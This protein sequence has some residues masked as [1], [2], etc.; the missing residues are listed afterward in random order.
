MKRIVVIACLAALAGCGTNTCP[1]VQQYAQPDPTGTLP[2][3]YQPGQPSQD[4]GTSYVGPVAAGGVGYIAGRHFR[5]VQAQRVQVPA[6][7]TFTFTP[8]RSPSRRR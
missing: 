2:Q 4:Q 1:S 8:A 7:R 3:D 6:R 5:R